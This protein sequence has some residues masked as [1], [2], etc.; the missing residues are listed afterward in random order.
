MAS[1]T[2]QNKTFLFFQTSIPWP[3]ARTEC[4]SIGMDLATIANQQELDAIA[5]A[6]TLS[7]VG[8]VS[9]GLNDVSAEGAFVWVDGDSS[10][11]RNW[12]T[13]EPNGLRNENCGTVIGY[14]G[15]G[16]NDLGC[17][18]WASFLCSGC[19]GPSCT[20]VTPYSQV[21]HILCVDTCR[22]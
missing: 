21:S 17:T 13:G 7:S 3:A 10:T 8:Q 18:T 12:A 5:A 4:L 20:Q 15:V 22:L 11:F 9:I 16:F 14:K 2:H 19:V 1:P 6:W